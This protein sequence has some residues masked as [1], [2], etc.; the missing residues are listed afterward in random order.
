MCFDHE[1]G[2]PISELGPGWEEEMQN[3]DL[4]FLS[5][6]GLGRLRSVSREKPINR[7]S[8]AAERMFPLP[9]YE[10]LVSQDVRAAKSNRKDRNW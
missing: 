5:L 9:V 7:V 1:K 8:H 6:L 3:F 10:S 4:S 2:W